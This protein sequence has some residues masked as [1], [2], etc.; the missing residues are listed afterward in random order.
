MLDKSH[1]KEEILLSI[2]EFLERNG[3]KETFE[4][5]NQKSNYQY[6]EQN[7]KKI[8]D[9]IKADKIP[10]LIVYI[11]DNIKIP[12][13]EKI[14]WIKMLKIKYYL[15]LVLNNFNNHLK[16]KESLDYLRTEITPLLNQD[17]ELLNILTYILFIKDQYL[18][19][20]LKTFYYLILMM[21]L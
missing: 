1:K 20:I 7:R 18:K 5:L 6:I 19:N 15:K 8:T 9:L 14:Y 17:T 4:K 2:L 3:Y 13:K 21:I 10:E 16:Q 11:K 12:N